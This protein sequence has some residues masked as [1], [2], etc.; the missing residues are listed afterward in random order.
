MCSGQHTLLEQQ[1]TCHNQQC[2]KIDLQGMLQ[3][4]PHQLHVRV[5]HLPAQCCQS[6]CACEVV[7]LSL[8]QLLVQGAQGLLQASNL[9]L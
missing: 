1:Q 8:T 9:N 3:G 2:R 6:L 5:A 7:S 4:E